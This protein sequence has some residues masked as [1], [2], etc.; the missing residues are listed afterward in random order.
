VHAKIQKP[1]DDALLQEI[2]SLEK[3]F[4]NIERETPSL[5]PVVKAFREVV[6][7]RAILKAKL[8]ECPDTHISPPDCTRFSDGYPWLTEETI[9]SFVDPWGDSVKS[10]V[11]HCKKPFPV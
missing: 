6:I 8:P 11:S 9:T 10:M 7:S 3:A 1:A 5:K 2:N 4:E